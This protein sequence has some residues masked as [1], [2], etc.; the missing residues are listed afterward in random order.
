MTT[1]DRDTFRMHVRI[2]TDVKEALEEFARKR[3]RSDAS[4]TSINRLV[5]EAIL[6]FLASR[7]YRFKHRE[8]PESKVKPPAKSLVRR[9]RPAAEEPTLEARA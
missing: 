8:P 4:S 2:H 9:K 5:A 3:S 7:G 1:Q 6:E